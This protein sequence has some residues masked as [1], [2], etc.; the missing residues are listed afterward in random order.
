M[1]QDVLI[2]QKSEKTVCVSAI[3]DFVF[4]ICDAVF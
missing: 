2:H 1:K 3:T 4:E